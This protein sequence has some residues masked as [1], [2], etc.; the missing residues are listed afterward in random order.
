MRLLLLGVIWSLFLFGKLPHPWEALVNLFIGPPVVQIP[1]AGIAM[2]VYWLMFYVTGMG[3]Y[4][5][6]VMLGQVLYATVG[7]LV[8]QKT[9]Q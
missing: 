5:V 9:K 1:K 3:L 4:L 8:S 6:A 2:I 7:G